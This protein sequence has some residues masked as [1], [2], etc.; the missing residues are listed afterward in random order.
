MERDRRDA[1]AGGWAWPDRRTDRGAAREEDRDL[2]PGRGELARPREYGYGGATR[3][4]LGG[5][6][7][8]VRS[9]YGRRELGGRWS[10]SGPFPGMPE[11]LRGRAEDREPL[12]VPRW[13]V[14]A[15]GLSERDA[16]IPGEALGDRIERAGERLER[17]MSFD[18]MPGEGL[19]DRVESSSERME[20]RVRDLGARLERGPFWGRGPKGYRRSDARITEDVSEVIARQGFIDASDVEVEVERGIVYL[21]GTV[22]HRDDRRELERL[23]EHVPGVVDV[24]NDLQAPRTT[25]RGAPPV[26]PRFFHRV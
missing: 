19:G 2:D 14:R 9:G 6:G 21:R 8:T 25:A 15:R 11:D 20:R 3:E 1:G 5:A 26:L 23:I 10:A 4:A 17:R 16:H 13:D 12:D 22:A 18:H 24:H 7:G